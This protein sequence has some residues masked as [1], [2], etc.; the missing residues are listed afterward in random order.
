MGWN[1]EEAILHYHKMGA[2]Q[3][4]GV[5]IRLLKEVQQEN[6]GS[7]SRSDVASI[8]SAYEI[9]PGI[10]F[11]LIK[12]IPS[13]RLEDRHSLEICA[14]PNCGKQQKLAELARRLQDQFGDKLEVKFVP[15]M[16]MCG[17]GPNIRFDG[18][19]CHNMTPL[20]LQE[21]VKKTL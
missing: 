21:M 12:R 13:L 3:D 16:R 11:A 4:Q 6:G 20:L 14:G 1:L 2:P 5:L 15:C 17:K 9:K 19:I 10:L 7:V 8:A 18:Q